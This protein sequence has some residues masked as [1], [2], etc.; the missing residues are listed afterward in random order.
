MANQEQKIIDTI[1]DIT[2]R[3]LNLPADQKV[4]AQSEFINDLGADSL[5]RV[6]LVMALET[7]FNITIPDEEAAKMNTVK[8]A[9]MAIKLHLESK[10]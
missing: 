9:A 2:K 10:E 3:E 4:E 8:D 1:I 5:D 7:E 6:E